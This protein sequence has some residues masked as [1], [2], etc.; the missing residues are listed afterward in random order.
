M[1]RKTLTLVLCLLATFALASIGFASWIISNPDVAVDGTT[2][3]DFTVYDAVEESVSLNVA[4]DKTGFIFG[5]PVTPKTFTDPWLKADDMEKDS[6]SV[7]MTLTITNPSRVV[8]GGLLV[9]IYVEDVESNNLLK[10]VIDAGYIACSSGT[11]KSE[12][13]KVGE[14]EKD[15]YVLTLP[16]TKADLQDGTEDITLTFAWGTKFGSDN[17]FNYYNGKEF[18]SNAVTVLKDLYAKLKTLK[19]NVLIKS[20]TSN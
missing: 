2:T 17:P 13:V 7:K 10:Q 8:D 12:K 6:L 5:A 9:Q 3:G 18:D 4:F 15:A 19:F 16:I 20:N 14:T 11:F 1:K